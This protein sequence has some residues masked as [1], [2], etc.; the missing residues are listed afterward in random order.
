MSL[1][2]ELLKQFR[3]S[4]VEMD[5]SRLPNASVVHK[6]LVPDRNGRAL[7]AFGCLDRESELCR[8]VI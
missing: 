1:D 2:L 8:G 5:A 7:H 3:F 4:V 6:H